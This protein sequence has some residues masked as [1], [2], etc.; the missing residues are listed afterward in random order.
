MSRRELADSPPY[1]RGRHHTDGTLRR[2]DATSVRVSRDTHYELGKLL[3][4]RESFNTLIRRL[5]AA[6]HGTR[7]KAT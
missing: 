6:Y 2:V 7:R 4:P 3:Q 5:I 1:V